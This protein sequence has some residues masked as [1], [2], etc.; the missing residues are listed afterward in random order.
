VP[1]VPQCL[2]CW[3]RKARECMTC[4]PMPANLLAC[5]A[6]PEPAAGHAPAGTA[7]AGRPEG[8]PLTLICGA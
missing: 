6:L 7:A 3:W 2:L 5:P 4:A 8:M 1:A